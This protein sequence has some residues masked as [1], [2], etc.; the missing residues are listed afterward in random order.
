MVDVR[1]HQHSRTPWRSRGRKCRPLFPSPRNS[2]RIR[3]KI[4][5]LLSTAMPIVSTRSRDPG[6]RPAPLRNRPSAAISSTP[7]S[8]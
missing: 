4:S 7:F 5:T 8:N 3:S 1:I 2:S 6:Q